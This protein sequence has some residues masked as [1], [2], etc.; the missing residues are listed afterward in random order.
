MRTALLTCLGTLTL[1]ACGSNPPPLTTTAAAASST[2]GASSTGAGNSGTGTG[3]TATSGTGNTGTASGSSTG[4]VNGGSTTGPGIEAGTL[5]IG[6]QYGL[7]PEA[8]TMSA[9]DPTYMYKCPPV[10]TLSS[11]AQ[12]GAEVMDGLGQLW[13]QFTSPPTNTISVWTDNELTNSCE[14][15]HPAMSFS[16]TEANNLAAL[17]FDASGNLWASVPQG[18]TILAYGANDLLSSNSIGPAY[19]LNQ[20]PNKGASSLFNPTGLAFDKFGTLWVANYYSVLAYHTATLAKAATGGAGNSLV[21]PDLVLTNA[22]AAG[23]EADGGLYNQFVYQYLAFDS[24]G[25]LWVTVQNYLNGPA[26][27]QILEFSATQLGALATNG[28]PTPIFTINE[29]TAQTAKSFPGWTSIAFDAKGNLW[30]GAHL[31]APNLYRFPAANLTTSGA[32]D[33]IITALDD[34]DMSLDFNLVFDPIPSG[35]PINR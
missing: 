21:P 2:G 4:G 9:T 30:G 20:N 7:A 24:S 11:P 15:R 31:S 19:M 10:A 35:L 23:V 25:D 6:G 8:L 17:A 34:V 22:Q 16:I 14:S 28:Q 26:T 5:W 3:G 33:I 18:N 13:T 32:P 1:A 29:T 12:G 27:S